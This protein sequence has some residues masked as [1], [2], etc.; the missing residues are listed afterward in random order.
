MPQNDSEFTRVLRGYDPEEVDR[1][2]NKLRRELLS[3]KT[4]HDELVETISILTAQLEELRSNA[5]LLGR[6][7]FSGLGSRLASTLTIAE[8]HAARLVSRAEADAHSLS[9]DAVSEAEN[10]RNAANTDARLIRESAN[11][12]AEEIVSDAQNRAKTVITDAEH[13]A[14]GLRNDAENAAREIRGASATEISNART[15]SKRELE[16][17]SAEAQRQ[18]AE[19]RLVLVSKRPDNVDVTDELINIFK[20]QAD[21]AARID[22]AEAEFL[23]R[24]QEAVTQTQ[25]YI[26]DAQVQ[27]ALA[28]K[29]A[30]ERERIALELEQ[31]A[32]ETARALREEAAG[33][34]STLASEAEAQAKTILAEAQMRSNKMLAD[35]EE[36]VADLRV[37]REAIAAH[38]EGLRLVLGQA[39]DV[40]SEP[41]EYLNI[42]Q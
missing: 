17:Q 22:E 14:D 2:V 6:P 12:A 42:N 37:E 7:T 16:K 4:D 32:I 18:I 34:V 26:D 39:S 33:R 1:S 15:T 23:V 25:K 28:R 11:V 20:V 29:N 36:T 19:A 35:A 13:F 21:N 24:H 8:E 10:I 40:M 9:V 30:V 41:G 38:F 27:A 31:E 5:E 3:L